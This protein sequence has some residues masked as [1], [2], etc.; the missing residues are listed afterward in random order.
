MLEL[1]CDRC[2][3]PL[4][5]PGALMFSPPA[6]NQGLVEKYHL[7]VDCWWLLA[8]EVRRPDAPLNETE[9]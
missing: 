3:A 7:C 9:R 5:Q 8:K 4:K 2:G 1:K 6:G